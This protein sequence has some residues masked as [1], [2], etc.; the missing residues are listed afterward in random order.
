ML[1]DEAEVVGE[2]DGFAEGFAVCVGLASVAVGEGDSVG[3]AVGVWV[4][5]EL[6]LGEG[7]GVCVGEFN[8]KVIVP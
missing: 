5:E 8:E 2:E 1:L 6:G 7:V 4:A 3:P